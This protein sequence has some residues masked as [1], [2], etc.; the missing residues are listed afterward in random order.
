TVNGTIQIFVSASADL[1]LEFVRL[2]AQTGT[3][4]LYY[5]LEQWT[6]DGSLSINADRPWKTAAWT[7]PRAEC[8]PGNCSDCTENSDHQ[9][10]I[11]T[12]NGE[13]RLRVVSRERGEFS[14]ANDAKSAT[15]V[16]RLSNAPTAPAWIGKPESNGKPDPSVI[17]RWSPSPEPDVTE[18]QFVREDPT[19]A[20]RV[21][22]VGASNPQANGCSRAGDVAYTCA[23]GGFERSGTYRYAFRALRPGSSS[24]RCALTN[25]SCVASPVGAVRTVTITVSRA[26]SPEPYASA[27]PSASPSGTTTAAPESQSPLAL[28]DSSTGDDLL[29]PRAASDTDTSR[30]T[31][32]VAMAGVLALAAGIFLIRRRRGLGKPPVG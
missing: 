15:F 20:E 21:F 4:P 14:D 32:P 31:L 28:P 24:T 25:A 8:A 2:E 26:A 7:D 29:A 5:C 3:D 23:N 1:P 17:L 16:V 9:H 11:P 13:Y 12:A 18:Y 30:S 22:A 27:D 19:G 6:G 10:G